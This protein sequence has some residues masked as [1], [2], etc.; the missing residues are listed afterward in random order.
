M[1]Y[2]EH[3]RHS[4]PRAI[5]IGYL[6]RA[7][8]LPVDW[9]RFW[10][11]SNNNKT[12]LPQM[13]REQLVDMLLCYCW[14]ELVVS[15]DGGESPQHCQCAIPPSRICR[16]GMNALSHMCCMD[17]LE[18]WLCCCHETRM[19]FVLGLFFWKMLNSPL[20]IITGTIHGIFLSEALCDNSP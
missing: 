14:A 18:L 20:Y 5:R 15:F 6:G 13:L 1:K 16:V 7:T 9:S 11:S 10:S 12:K 19:C 8:F 3:G 17:Q 4:Q 2:Y